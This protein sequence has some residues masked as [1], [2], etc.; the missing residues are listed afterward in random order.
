M[1][2]TGLVT[3]RLEGSMMAKTA[4]H[5]AWWGFFRQRNQLRFQST[6]GSTTI[7]SNR[8]LDQ[9]SPGSITVLYASTVDV[10]FN[11]ITS[12]PALLAR[13]TQEL[14]DRVGLW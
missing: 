5:S 1:I 2:S 14:T 13:F 8:V 3:Y 10:L 12:K 9:L 6:S 11:V 7:G 4:A